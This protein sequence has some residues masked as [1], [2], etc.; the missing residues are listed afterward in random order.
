MPRPEASVA[1]PP[2][3]RLRVYAFDPSLDTQLE[4][5][6]INL[7]TLKVPWEARPDQTHNSKEN[8]DHPNG[9]AEDLLRSGPVGDYLEVVDYDPAS[10]CFYDPVDLNAPYVLAQDGLA[11]SEGNPQFHQ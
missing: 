6:V 5:A 3:R 7:L 4:T 11:P 10:G 1:S 9:T 8:P 2:F